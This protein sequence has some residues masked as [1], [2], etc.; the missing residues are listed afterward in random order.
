M[1]CIKEGEFRPTPIGKG[2][3]YRF[4]F[5]NSEYYFKS[6]DEM[7][8]L[9]ADIPE[10]IEN[11]TELLEKDYLVN[12]KVNITIEEASSR[13]V[14]VL[15]AVT[16]PG[17]YTIP[18]DQ[19]LTLSTAI[20]YAGGFSEVAA[21]DRIRIMRTVGARKVTR[22]V[23]MKEFLSGS[24]TAKDIPLKPGDVITVLESFL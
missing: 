13:Y 17:S 1:L 22:K 12:P 9:F 11:I 16:N 7:K 6:Q 8:S 18:P 14:V 2:R 19:Q 23:N 20:A 24:E 4:G 3:G 15:G 21:K 5:P 10:A